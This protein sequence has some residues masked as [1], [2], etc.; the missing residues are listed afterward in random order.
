MDEPGRADE[1]CRFADS[2]ETNSVAMHSSASEPFSNEASNENEER[3]SICSNKHGTFKLF[4]FF[5]V[6]SYYCK[7]VFVALFYKQLGLPPHFVGLLTGVAPFSA[8]TGAPI[9]GYIADRTNSRKAILLVGLAVQTVTPLICLI[10]HPTRYSC[11]SDHVNHTGLL[12][13]QAKY[14]IGPGVDN[15]TVRQFVPF[16]NAGNNNAVGSILDSQNNNSLGSIFEK[17]NNTLQEHHTN[18]SNVTKS[19]SPSRHPLHVSENPDYL[20]QEVEESEARYI[21][22]FLFVT[23]AIG[24]FFGGVVHNI[25]DSA[26][27]HALGESR[28]EYGRIFMF[29][30]I[31]TVMAALLVT[32]MAHFRAFE[33][34]EQLQEDYKY[35]MYV[36]S[37]F[38]GLAL[39]VGFKLPI[40]K[41]DDQD[42]MKRPDSKGSL[43]AFVFTFRNSSFLIV[44]LYLGICI[45]TFY[46]FMFWYLT[47]INHDPVASVIAIIMVL[48]NFALGGAFALSGYVI[49]KLGAENIINCSLLLMIAVFTSYAFLEDAWWAIIPDVLHS[50]SFG[51]GWAASV[52]FCAE[53]APADFVATAQGTCSFLT[54][55]FS[56]K[57]RPSWIQAHV[58]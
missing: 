45:G 4:Y 31:G 27:V 22:I 18:T 21:F 43:F 15:S 23:L 44:V 11:V 40:P 1:L 58:V 13:V 25:A 20:R 7:C 32:A 37:I 12:G 26:T 28:S 47:D 6:A 42:Q 10:P 38:A 17:Q 56:I 57:W 50:L 29:G 16:P 49:R 8:G 53:Y 2:P 30:N 3:E 52:T 9:L 33:I 39:L 24:E 19:V 54:I 14:D 36:I 48:R 35:S 55:H 51:L 5:F 41:W 46:A 34:C